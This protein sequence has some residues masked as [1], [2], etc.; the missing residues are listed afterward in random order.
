MSAYS[1][2]LPRKVLRAIAKVAM[3]S[4]VNIAPVPAS[5]LHASSVL[6]NVKSLL[7]RE[8]VE[9]RRLGIGIGIGSVRSVNHGLKG[10]PIM[11]C[12]SIIAQTHRT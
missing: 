2:V 8:R 11:W 1:L 10:N 4:I 12:F 6:A 3:E 7:V 9:V 5:K